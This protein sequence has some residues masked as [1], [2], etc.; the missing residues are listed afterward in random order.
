MTDDT[1]HLTPHDVRAQ[2]FQRAMRGYDPAQVE[3][4]KERVA[5]ELD[6]VLREKGRME[7]RLKGLLEQLRSF[8]ER[9]RAMND[10]L[11]AAQQLRADLQAQ[12]G[13]EAEV[14]MAQARQEAE[15]L[16]TAGEEEVRGARLRAEAALRQMQAYVTTFRSILDRHQAELS[17]LEGYLET[18]APSPAPGEVRATT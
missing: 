11:V 16:I 3:G 7:E 13:R 4:F 14:L 6:R 10:A 17:G 18:E 9:E 12:A 1:F 15:R 2:E 8:R 5:E